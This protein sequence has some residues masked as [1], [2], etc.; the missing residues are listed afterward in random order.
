M[1]TRSIIIARSLPTTILVAELFWFGVLILL[2]TKVFASE[3]FYPLVP[4]TWTKY[5]V[6]SCISPIAN[7]TAFQAGAGR[8]SVGPSGYAKGTAYQTGYHLAPGSLNTLYTKYRWISGDHGAHL[9]VDGNITG[10]PVHQC[11][12]FDGVTG[13]VNSVSPAIKS[14]LVLPL[15]VD[16]G[17]SVSMV[18]QTAAAY[19]YGDQAFPYA[20]LNATQCSAWWST[21]LTGQA[22]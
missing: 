20:Q 19:E 4:G 22:P 7:T 1:I 2:A 8:G 3:T 6:M 18:F 16:E 11:L 17:F 9:C 14:T 15:G 12:D 5:S 10:Y 13:T 21:G